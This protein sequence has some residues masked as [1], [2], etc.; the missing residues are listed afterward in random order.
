MCCV[1][2]PSALAVSN[3]LLYTLRFLEDY[4]PCVTAA[5]TLAA[6]LLQ[7]GAEAHPTH[8]LAGTVTIPQTVGRRPHQDRAQVR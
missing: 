4:S 1:E 7:A 2:A 5:L 3:S 8:R 6:S